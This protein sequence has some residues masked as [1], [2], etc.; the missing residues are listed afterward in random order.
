MTLSEALA[1]NHGAQKSR[2]ANEHAAHAECICAHPR[3]WHF[4]GLGSCLECSCLGFATFAV[5]GS[6][7]PD[8]HGE[9]GA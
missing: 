8:E 4:R 1:V 6:R 3:G 9:A 2:E 5:D 7:E